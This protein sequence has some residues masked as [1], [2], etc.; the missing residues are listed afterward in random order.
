[1]GQV[2]VKV[3][4]RDFTL[5][6]D[7]GEEPHLTELAQY[8]DSKAKSLSRNFNHVGDTR[9]LLMAGLLAADELGD[10]VARIEEL[11]A[12]VKVLRGGAPAPSEAGDGQAVRLLQDV[13]RRLEG[14]AERVEAP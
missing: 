8:L 9:L 7:D 12:Q 3:A 11:E 13:A 1:M 4:G 5:A 2:V 14:I 10:A 6:C